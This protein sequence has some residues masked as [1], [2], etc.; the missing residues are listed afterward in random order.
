[1]PEMA[2]LAEA[3]QCSVEGMSCGSF[4]SPKITRSFVLYSLAR[5]DQR[6][7][8]AAS[9]TVPVPMMVSR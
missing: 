1:M 2:A 6:F 8:K 5:R 4:I 9:L 7:E 3:S